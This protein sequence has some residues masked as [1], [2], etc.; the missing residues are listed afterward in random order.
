MSPQYKNQDRYVVKNKFKAFLLANRSA[1]EVDASFHWNSMERGNIVTG[2]HR[3]YIL[4]LNYVR[5]F[6]SIAQNKL[7]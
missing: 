5:F 1:I 7:N 2:V 3:Y 6:V 4:N